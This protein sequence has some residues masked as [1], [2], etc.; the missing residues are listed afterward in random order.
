MLTSRERRILYIVLAVVITFVAAAVAMH[1]YRQYRNENA[2]VADAADDANKNILHNYVADDEIPK[3][4]DIYENDETLEPCDVIVEPKILE[5][6]I[7]INFEGST[8]SETI[9]TISKILIDH[10]I[11][12]T[13]FIP[14][15]D[16]AEDDQ[17]A[18]YIKQ[19]DGDIENG[20]LTTAKHFE[21]T[22]YKDNIENVCRAQQIYA[23]V[24]DVFPA[25]IK[26]PG[27]V[28]ND[29]LAKQ[30]K[31]TGFEAVATCKRYLNYQSFRNKK[32]AKNYVKKLPKG[33]IVTVKLD[34]YLDETEYEKK[35]TDLDPAKDKQ[36]DLKEVK[37]V[38]EGNLFHVIE[39][40]CEGINDCELET[41]YIKDIEANSIDDLM[42]DYEDLVEDIDY[43]NLND[44]HNYIYTTDRKAVFTFRGIDDAKKV[45]AVISKCA[46][47]GIT[48]TY[49]IT[50]QEASDYPDT[51]KKIADA[52]FEIG[53]GG[54]QGIWMGDAS[55]NEC[56]DEIYMGDLMLSQAGYETDLYMPSNSDVTEDLRAAATALDVEIIGYNFSLMRP[57]YYK[58]KLSASE[59]MY[60]SFGNW[61]R[62]I[63]RG[64]IFSFNISAANNADEVS[65][66]LGLV[67][68][69][70]I[71]PTKWGSSI[72]QVTNYSD[73]ASNTWSYPAYGGAAG[74]IKKGG[75]LAAP[76]S[77]LEATR[78]IGNEDVI[79]NGFD[80]A[81]LAT[82]DKSGKIGNAG[83]TVF[84]TFDDWGDEQTIGRL[85]C[86]LRNHGVKATF[87]IKTQYIS[88]TGYNLVRAIAEGG[89]DVASHTDTHMTV[90]VTP[91]CIGTLQNDLVRSNQKL[92]AACGDT[93][94]LTYYFR[95]PTLAINAAGMATIF[96]CGY[97][98]IIEGDVSTHDYEAK[99]S[100]E[101]LDQLINGR[102]KNDGVTRDV[103]SDGTI[104]VMHMSETAPY[105]P[106]A[107]DKYISYQQSLGALG[108]HMARL[109]DYL[110]P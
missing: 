46:E 1:F 100:D 90:D 27:T 47:L 42:I 70:K 14:A 32:T 105:T 57:D 74:R 96:D 108:Y 24:A 81:T 82:L 109:S 55:Y 75:N 25:I 79:L 4:I 28:L 99:S 10:N 29:D 62:T 41:V 106:A 58:N 80:S 60:K 33:A 43:D 23:E 110:A 103:V 83:H 21:E 40:L 63:T 72:V 67:Y 3:A 91:D 7:S 78:Y 37:E 87:F 65:E 101:L 39:W 77:T 61:K 56:A 16:I 69:R 73:A 66:L 22:G 45:D 9:Q 98:Y 35:I 53:N 92:A 15:M 94:R 88:D 107:V 86:I 59:V 50:G 18:D 51:L 2:T 11:K 12:A 97:H 26:F 44:I 31:A 54:M 93:G 17:I 89:H 104:I 84:L 71:L 38:P 6:Q 95:P 19:C 8:D 34:G 30:A 48:G 13:F 5:K 85:L 68:E 49:F 20:T 52:G 102:L 76:L 64:D 36:P